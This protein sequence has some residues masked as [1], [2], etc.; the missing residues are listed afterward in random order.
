MITDYYGGSTDRTIL[1]L[2]TEFSD[3]RP[4]VIHREAMDADAYDSWHLAFYFKELLEF[5]EPLKNGSVYRSEY[6]SE[7]EEPPCLSDARC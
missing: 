2:F 3:G 1:R 7:G 6:P 5:P 4:Q